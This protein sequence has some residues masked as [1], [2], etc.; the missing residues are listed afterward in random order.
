MAALTESNYR[1]D[2]LDEKFDNLHCREQVTFAIAE[3]VVMAEVCG[4][5]TKSTPTTGTAG[6]TNT[7]GGTCTGVTGDAETILG[8]YTL[9]CTVVADASAGTGAMFSV[10]N[11]EGAALPDAEA[12]VAFANEQT[13]FTINTS[14]AA[15]IVGDS[16]TI[17][18]A[19]GSGQVKA[20][21]LTAVDGTQDAY[22]IS[23]GA[24]GEAAATEEGILI[25]RDANIVPAY[26]TWPAGASAGQKAAGLAQLKLKGIT[27]R[28]SEA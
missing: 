26:L 16:F 23:Y 17:T 6:G 24:Y 20:L 10:M 4:K 5:V 28:G 19:A 27:E 13:N 14:G 7:G 1:S 8:I 18:V 21:S 15:F 9:E 22:G 12:D 25:V 3:D 11:P 2:W